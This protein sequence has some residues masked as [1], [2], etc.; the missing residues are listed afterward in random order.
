M[1][2]STPSL[3]IRYEDDGGLKL[4]I[5]RALEGQQSLF[6]VTGR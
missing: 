5:T 3:P 4:L 2:D 1:E 6:P